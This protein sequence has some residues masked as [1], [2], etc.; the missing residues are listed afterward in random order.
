MGD[1]K[2]G[3]VI[4]LWSKVL[5][6]HDDLSTLEI[7]S[8]VNEMKFNKDKHRELHLSS[9]QKHKIKTNWLGSST[10]GRM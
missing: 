7:W 5:A 2:L 6:I 8:E 1:L 10:S 3:G 9:N 4:S